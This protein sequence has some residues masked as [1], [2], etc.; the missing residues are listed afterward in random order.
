[1]FCTIWYHLYNFKNVKNANGGV[2][3]NTPPWVFFTFFK[4]YKWYQLAQHITII[5]KWLQH[6]LHLPQ[7]VV[8]KWC[9]PLANCSLIIFGGFG[10]NQQKICAGKLEK[11]RNLLKNISDWRIKLRRSSCNFL[12]VNLNSVKIL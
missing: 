1:M 2:K 6:Q 9:F 10:L 3:S 5:F 4:L 8:Q 11:N 12:H 7:V